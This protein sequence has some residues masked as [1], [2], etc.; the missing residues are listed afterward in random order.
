MADDKRKG[1]GEDS[2]LSRCYCAEMRQ[3]KCVICREA[4]AK[5]EERAACKHWSWNYTARECAVAAREM[6]WSE[7]RLRSAMAENGYKPDQIAS[8]IYEFELEE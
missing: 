1:S 3:G 5:E 2:E 8:V 4:E 6:G 7:S